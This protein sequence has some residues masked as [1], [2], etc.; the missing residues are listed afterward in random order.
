M[1]D[2]LLFSMTECA[3][4]FVAMAIEKEMET[5]NRVLPALMAEQGKFVLICGDEVIG[6]FVSYEDALKI[7]YE[8]CG[9]KSFLVKQIQVVEQIQYFSRELDFPCPT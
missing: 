1:A 7:G 5:Y 8:K 6:T 3:T 4:K 9:V 2:L